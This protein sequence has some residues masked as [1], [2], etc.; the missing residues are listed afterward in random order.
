MAEHGRGD[1]GIVCWRAGL[2]HVGRMA[3]EGSI[4]SGSPPVYLADLELAEAALDGDEEAAAEIVGMLQDAKFRGMLVGRGATHT[5]AEDLVGDLIG[6]CFGGEKAKGGL[7]RLLEHYNGTCPL[8]AYLI[9][10]GCNRLIN[11]IRK[12]K[13]KGELPQREDQA[14]D[15][16]DA[17][18]GAVAEGPVE[19]A[20]VEL[21]RAAVMQAL[22]EVDPQ[23]LVLLRLV[24]SYGI[25]Q[26]RVGAMWGLTEATISRALSALRNELMQSILRHLREADSGLQIEWGDF[27]ALCA[28]SLDLFSGAAISAR[29]QESRVEPA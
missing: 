4:A 15:R 28:E 7:H 9:R 16:F 2:Q 29:I 5:L 23:K 24:H 14:G 10:V 22:A 18:P 12:D 6:D 20:V 27:L 11:K 13:C 3:G 1:F 21:L 19:D 17:L 25:P 26:K 8:E